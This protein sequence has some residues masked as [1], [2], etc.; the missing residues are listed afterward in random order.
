M[1]RTCVDYGF[2]TTVHRPGLPDVHLGFAFQHQAEQACRSLTAALRYT[3]HVEGT[4]VTWSSTPDGIAPL[5]SVPTDPGELAYLVE[6][7]PNDLPM[8]HAFPDLFSRLVAQQGYDSAA[9]IWR[10]ACFWLDDN[11]SDED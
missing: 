5:P 6:Q 4:T 7:D 3:Q 11:D 8:G 10:E 2:I 9:R 1:N